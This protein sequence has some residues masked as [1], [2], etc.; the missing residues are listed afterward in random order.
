MITTGEGKF[1]RVVAVRMGPG[2]DV[3]KGI[4]QVCKEKGI[5]NGII[6]EGIGSLAEANLFNPVPIPEKKAGY[7]YSEPTKLSGPIELVSI[8]GMI[9]HS[10]DG[11]ILIHAHY[12]LSDVYA[13]GHGGHL[14]EGNK[15][16]L[17][18]DIMIAEVEG[19]KMGRAYDEDLE[20][21]IFRPETMK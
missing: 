10:D 11:E 13:N 6:V 9:C 16:L 7:G 19:L 21:F 1:G 8:S 5:K 18:V 2:E 17:T 12:S 4:E 14:I 15:V 3:L 20:V